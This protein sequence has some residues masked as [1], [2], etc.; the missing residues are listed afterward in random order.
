MNKF[1]GGYN[2]VAPTVFHAYTS[3]GVEQEEAKGPALQNLDLVEKQLTGK[4][5]FS[6]ETFGFLDLAFGWIANY[7]G[8]FEETGRIKLLDRERFPLILEWK[9]NFSDIPEI[10]ENWPDR[11]KLI[12]K[13]R[14]MREFYISVTAAKFTI[15]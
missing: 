3:Q 4:K 10:K 12:T 14:L 15:S 2:T 13:F 7:L 9:E 8:I 1:M 5:F 11:E 6:G